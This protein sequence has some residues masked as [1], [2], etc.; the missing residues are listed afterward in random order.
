M[1]IY[2]KFL[3]TLVAASVIFCL[4]SYGALSAPWQNADIGSVGAT[5]DSAL[6]NDTYTVTGAGA[7]IWNTA[8][9]FQFASQTLSGDGIIIARVASLQNTDPWAK[10]AV[11]IR[12]SLD[13]NSRW[14][15]VAVTPTNGVTFQWRSA[16]GGNCD[17]SVTG[18]IVAPAWLKLFRSGNTFTAYQSADGATWTQ[19]GSPTDISMGNSVNVGLAVTSHNDP[20]LCTA[21]FDSVQVIHAPVVAITAPTTGT[22]YDP[23][24]PVSITINSNATINSGAITKV[25]FFANGILLKEAVSAPYTYTW[26]NVPTGTYSLKATAIADSGITADSAPVTVAVKS[27]PPPWL[28]ADIGSVGYL[29]VGTFTNGT[30]TV[31]GSGAD[32]WDTADAFQYVYQPLNGDGEIIARVTGVQNTSDWAKAGIMIRETL[33]ANSRWALAAVTSS[34]GATFQWRSATGGDCDYSVT[35]GVV[36][37]SWVRLVRVGSTITAFSSSDGANWIPLGVPTS[38]SMA[39]SV[40]VGMA[41]TAHDNTKLNTST[42]DNVLVRTTPVV[43]ITTPST[44]TAF[45]PANP[46][47]ITI[48]ANATIGAG[49]IT[50]VQFFANG[51]LLNEALTAPYTYT[52][53]NVPIGTYSLKATAVADNGTTADSTPVTVSVKSLPPPW[54]N[55]DIGSVGYLGVGSFANGTFTVMGSG[56]D[57]WNTADAFQYVYQP[58]TGNGEIIARVTDVENTDSWAKAGIMIRESLAADSRWALVAVTPTNGVTFQWRSSTGGNCDFSATGGIVAPVWLK[59]VRS[60]NTFTAYQ[61]ADGATWTQIGSPT[62]L[63]MG[64][65]VNVGMAVTAH[66]NTKLNTSTFDN[67]QVLAAPAVAITA[68]TTGAVFDPSNPV[69]I[70]INVNASIGAGAVTKV[71]FFANGILLNE[72]PNAPYTYT[73]M[74]VPIGAYT[75]KATAIA[76][77]GAT[78]DSAPVTVFVRS[79]PPPWQSADIGSVG[80]LG[81]GSFSGG[82]FT[83][84]GSGA[85]I[86]NTTDAFQYVYQPLSGDGEIIARVTGVQNTDP[87]A[88]AAVM[89]RE[90][91][92]ANSRWALVA[93][94]PSSGVT[95]QWRSATGGTCDFSA[96]SGIV[97]PIWLKLV[98]SGNT[99]TAYRSADG[100]TWTQV[101]SPTDISMGSSVNVGMAVT[102]HDNTKLNSSTFD[103]VIVDQPAVLAAPSLLAANLTTGSQVH[104]T[105]TDN[106]NNETG[107]VI[108]RKAEF[109]GTYAPVASPNTNATSADDL[110]GPETVNYS[111]RIKAVNASGSSAW[112][113]EVNVFVDQTSPFISNLMP[114]DGSYT[115]AFPYISAYYS[116]D[117]GRPAV[118]YLDGS[119]IVVND[120][121]SSFD[122]YAS[123]LSGGIHSITVSDQFGNFANTSWSF[124]VDTVPPDISNLIPADGSYT[125]SATNISALY[126]DNSGGPVVAYLDGVPAMVFY[127]GSSFNFYSSSL[128]E[129]IHSVAVSDQFGNFSNTSWSFTLD[130][131][132]PV[133]SNQTPPNGSYT[134]AYPYISASYS[135]NSG[136]PVIVYLD[137]IQM[138]VNDNGSSFNFNASGLT[139]GTHTIAVSDQAGNFLATSWSF[140][141]DASPPTI[142]IIAPLDGS[143]TNAS[144][145]IS[146]SYSDNDSGPLI[147]Y[148]DRT[149]ITVNDYGTSFDFHAQNLSEGIHIIAVSDQVGNFSTTSWLFYVDATA[150]TIGINSPA[151]G[152][153]T[154]ASPYISASYSDNSG[155]PVVVY[156]DGS[157]I[158]VTDNGSSFYF[159][160]SGLTNGYHSVAVSDQF[161]NFA[162]TSWSFNVVGWSSGGSLA[163]ARER[164]TATLLPSDK[165]LVTGGD[166]NS[167]PLE[168]VELYDPM[169]NTWSTA[170]NL[171]TARSDHTA[172]LLQSGKVLVTGGFNFSGALDSVDLYDPA[173]NT[174]SAAGRL[175]TARY[176]PT[177]TLLPSGKVLVAGGVGNS[178]PLA[179]DSAELYDPALNTW[180]PAGRLTTARFYFTATLLPCGKV[181]VAGGFNYESFPRALDSAELYDPE[182]NTWAP[183]GNLNWARSSHTMTLLTSGKVLVA[184]GYDY[185]SARL[186]SAELY[187]PMSN[188]WSTAGSLANAR[189]NHT[190]T[191]L[192]SGKVLAVSG[193]GN[194][195]TLDS[196]ELYDPMSN[197]WS[198][199]G[200]LTNSRF[201]HTATLL[202]SGKVLVAGG[203]TSDYN[204]NYNLLNSAELFGSATNPPMVI[205]CPPNKLVDATS[206]AGAVVSYDLATAKDIVPIVTLF[207]YSKSTNTIFP[208][209]VTTVNVIGVDATDNTTTA[210]FNV[211]VRQTALTF[212]VEPTDVAVGSDIMPGVVVSIKDQNGTIETDRTDSV[213]LAIGT[214]PVSGT[215]SGTLTRAAIN[216]VAAFSGLDIDKAGNNYTLQASAA[217]LATAVSS[218]FNVF[219]P[220]PNAPTYLAATISQGVVSLTWTDN[221]DYE[222]GFVIERKSGLGGPYT[223]IATPSANVTSSNDTSVPVNGTYYYRIKAVDSVGFSASAWSNV[224]SVTLGVDPYLISTIAG[225][226]IT[227]FGNDGVLATSTSLELPAGVALDFFGNIYI[228]DT[229]NH[230]IRRVNV[231]TGNIETI[232]GTGTAGLSGD[233]SS[234]TLATIS[235][236]RAVVLDAVGNIYIADTG[237]HRIRMIDA[238]TGNISTVA[239]TVA[240]FSGDGGPASAAKL[241]SPT[242][243]GVGSDG[244]IFIADRD[245]NRI[246]Q[247]ATDGTISTVAGTGNAAFSGDGTAATAADLNSPTAV[248]VYF[249]TIF[250]VDSGNARVR[251]IAFDGTISTVAGTGAQAYSGDGG[252]ATDA[253]LDTPTGLSVDIFGNLFVSEANHIR[254]INADDSTIS[255]LT[256]QASSAFSGDGGPAL[257]ADIGA[258]SYQLTAQDNGDI[259]FTDTTNRR[260]RKLSKILPPST[261]QNLSAVASATPTIT[262][263]WTDTSDNERE[264]VIERSVVAGA[265]SEIGRTAA[266]AVMWIDT[267]VVANTLYTYRVYSLNAA[268]TSVYSNLADAMPGGNAPPTVAI[269][270][271]SG[272]D[273]ITESTTGLTVLG[274]DDGGEANLIY[275]WTALPNTATFSLN[276]SNSAKDTAASFPAPGEY[277]LTVTISDAGALSVTDTIVVEVVA[278]PR[279][280]ITPNP[281][282]MGVNATQ[283]FSAIVS[284]QFGVLVNKV[285]PLLHGIAWADIGS[286]TTTVTAAQ[287]SPDGHA[288]AVLLHGSAVDTQWASPLSL[289]QADLNGRTMTASVWLKSGSGGHNV[290]LTLLLP[291][292]TPNHY[293]QTVTLT[294]DWAQYTLTQL[295]DLSVIDTQP[296]WFVISHGANHNTYAWSAQVEDGASVLPPTIDWSVDASAG[297]ITDTG[298][299]TSGLFEGHFQVLAFYGPYSGG[300]AVTII[301]NAPTIS[302][303]TLSESPVTGTTVDLHAFADDDGGES[304]L[305]YFWSID[306]SA[307]GDVAIS[308]NGDNASKN[309]TLTFVK[310]GTYNVHLVV[311]DGGGK[312]STMDKW[313]VVSQTVGSLMD[314]YL[315][316]GFAYCVPG[317]IIDFVAIVKDQFY[318]AIVPLPTITWSNSDATHPLFGGMMN[319]DGTFYA[320]NTEGTFTVFA[321]IGALTTTAQVTIAANAPQISSIAANPNP[322]LGTMSELT[323]TVPGNRDY[324]YH[325]EMISGPQPIVFSLNDLSFAQST[326]AHFVCSGTYVIQGTITDQNNGQTTSRRLTLEVVP[327]LTILAVQ[328][329]YADLNVGDTLQYV[330]TGRDQFGLFMDISATLTTWSVDTGGT[331]GSANGL[332]TAAAAG[333]STVSLTSGAG[334]ATGIA[335]ASI[336]N[337]PGDGG[338]QPPLPPT[339]PP[340]GQPILRTPNI[341]LN[342]P[343]DGTIYAADSLGNVTFKGK[344]DADYDLSNVTIS[345]YV[346]DKN[347]QYVTPR[348]DGNFQSDVNLVEGKHKVFVSAMAIN[349]ETGEEMTAFSTDR[350]VWVDTTTPEEFKITGPNFF[351]DYYG[352]N[353]WIFGY[354]AFSNPPDM[355]KGV[356]IDW[357]NGFTSRTRFSGTVQDNGITPTMPFKVELGTSQT[358]LEPSSLAGSNWEAE[359]KLQTT[360]TS[361]IVN[362]VKY[363]DFHTDALPQYMVQ[364]AGLNTIT[365]TVIDKPVFWCPI[366]LNPKTSPDGPTVKI[367]IQK[368]DEILVGITGGVPNTGSGPVIAAPP[369][370]LT[371][372]VYQEDL[373]YIDDQG[374]K[375]YTWHKGDPWIPWLFDTGAVYPHQWI[376]WYAGYGICSA[377]GSDYS[378]SDHLIWNDDAYFLQTNQHVGPEVGTHDLVKLKYDNATTAGNANKLTF[379]NFVLLAGTNFNDD[380]YPVKLPGLDTNSDNTDNGGDPDYSAEVTVY[381]INVNVYLAD[382]TQVSDSDRQT[383][384]FPFRLDNDDI[385]EN[386]TPDYQDT[387]LHVGDQNVIKIVVNQPTPSTDLDFVFQTGGLSAFDGGGRV[388]REISVGTYEL[389]TGASIPASQLPV[390]FLWQGG[391]YGMLQGKGV[392]TPKNFTISKK[393][394]F[395]LR[396]HE[397]EQKI[398]IPGGSVTMQSR[399]TGE[400]QIKTEDVPVTGRK[401]WDFGA[402]SALRCAIGQK[403]NLT[404]GVSG[405]DRKKVP[406]LI[407]GSGWEIE[408]EKIK[409]QIYSKESGKVEQLDSTDLESKDV[410]FYW[411]SGDQTNNHSIL[412]NVALAMSYYAGDGLL[413]SQWANAWFHVEHPKSALPPAPTQSVVVTTKYPT[414]EGKTVVALIKAPIL[415][416]ATNDDYKA[417]IVFNATVTAGDDN[418]GKVTYLQTFKLDDTIQYKYNNV[419]LQ[420]ENHHTVPGGAVDESQQYDLDFYCGVNDQTPIYPKPDQTPGW[421]TLK[422]PEKWLVIQKKQTLDTIYNSDS[423]GSSRKQTTM[424][425]IQNGQQIQTT[426]PIDLQI[427]S[428]NWETYLMF[429]PDGADSIWVSLRVVKW[430]MKF[431]AEDKNGNWTVN[432]K[433]TNWSMNP[434]SEET[435]EQPKWES[436]AKTFL[437][438]PFVKTGTPIK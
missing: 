141:V 217:G 77:S 389:Y 232:V 304:T 82:A 362:A 341:S 96:T 163:T 211:T 366:I 317:G 316:P 434:A 36:A 395:D 110:V 322:V 130:T 273:F 65:S 404:A 111:Y 175:T 187:D 9:A 241:S 108:E 161:G 52:W 50:K 251:S 293:T 230:R 374:Q 174:W 182:T 285:D 206:P 71:Q 6:S 336:F 44:G 342:T 171:S 321:T 13:A 188:A 177:A 256:G 257:N 315:I 8:D 340:P 350:D 364:D 216:G 349:S 231:D 393:M 308:A 358:G 10:A 247:I 261:P 155:G 46:V 64:S 373:T 372:W 385:D 367:A 335:Y 79:L 215:L 117:S 369:S 363:S 360:G 318:N 352:N 212:S 384:Q 418:S 225:N 75:L 34:N 107:F 184:G 54:L 417:G 207:S 195:G 419:I 312:Y 240:G 406:P 99:F 258:G 329:T 40:Y 88:K 275:T 164:H 5:G 90:S 186:D 204:Y 388:F 169:S 236:P 300:S 193:G 194:S 180:S 22:V 114:I 368:G 119:P 248:C 26:T 62:I 277:I 220:L 170:G 414:K 201:F 56:A 18:G 310:A 221:S 344:I 265:F 94:T 151:D 129:G 80:Y 172:T 357:A 103:N 97:A 431:R 314:F 296:A 203:F 323:M 3:F 140:N 200:S 68:P 405:L 158:T 167:G 41:V 416:P 86:W 102:A 60:G 25:Q 238:Q 370:G 334:L 189:G 159:S 53:M 55:A 355:S 339:P 7:D 396:G 415:S 135:D 295:I 266:N 176:S 400:A 157:Q 387:P 292:S 35:G 58:L 98:R 185:N 113:N 30:F 237:N 146:A 409:N 165:V 380:G 124:T 11:M 371:T 32:I 326:T 255:T 63:S 17:Y 272:G 1:I 324:L 152:S 105:W 214:N 347:Q 144:P 343:F 73:W 234:A 93:V 289:S 222:T 21:T 382:G 233:G 104:L 92:D 311:V 160:A 38:I 291:G 338:P 421:P 267:A 202:T 346:D 290:D 320:Y 226:G 121:G 115:S 14:A 381:D 16:T 249:D 181:L 328:P 191:L 219:T 136:R 51:T 197:T 76:D 298:L 116:D 19:V 192:T 278:V 235:S 422:A 402:P 148:L 132:P 100:G 276:A 138:A 29:G 83:V 410:S 269:P 89:F 120:Y 361:K 142:S 166:G 435:T 283:Q 284:D 183:A 118:V 383:M 229:G 433:E 260:I 81:V 307:P 319:S 101:G 392:F 223:Q 126:F 309:T 430:H 401:P 427:Y 70:T 37:P 23:A 264:F 28:N 69:S 106:S 398:I 31:L 47:S 286:G 147:V 190:A 67:V 379:Q 354:D 133:I 246:R 394:E 78:A 403:I 332:F 356:P 199:S 432:D 353:P 411:V 429:K 39:Q 208:I 43:A 134:N 351:N 299:F 420:T 85:D 438:T 302:D 128:T 2:R 168:G 426:L 397:V 375:Q 287:A 437:T 412:M 378:G 333:V 15:L 365:G 263:T 87:W 153:D 305:N 425:Q 268:G 303:I 228:A 122:C 259:L 423:P 179:L 20:T 112:S 279:V 262:L 205:T 149:Q 376:T 48:N 209:G 33:A 390:T 150:P 12:E 424:K 42:F 173:S 253:D 408:G 84:M 250:F 297:T 162:N 125:N 178:V 391:K 196:A 66:D 91:L 274:A 127:N 123:G 386:G 413:T 348:S 244:S 224:A 95:F 281:V 243:L 72:A 213:T 239:G 24:N 359:L 139:E 345:V 57:I 331:I 131:T 399:D 245:N 254:V 145:Y 428:S 271:Q 313:V 407:V 270:I 227:G 242:G 198:A 210:S 218:P 74:N 377:P 4:R 154:N 137:G 436:S 288:N 280:V 27:L 143:N 282:S 306:S 294:S 156:L 327:T 325:W 252:L 109:G 337:G 49:A 330:A 45:D 301:N 59:L 61:S